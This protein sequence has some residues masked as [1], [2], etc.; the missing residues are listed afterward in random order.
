ME[1]MTSKEMLE[2]AAELLGLNQRELGIY[3]G[4]GTRTI[5]SWMTG[6]REC[7][8]YVAE[9]AYRLAQIDAKALED[10]DPTTGMLRW[11]VISESEHDGTLDVYGSKSEAM[12]EA[13]DEWERMH[14]S[15]KRD[16]TRHEVGLVHV[17]VTEPTKFY[18]RFSWF[19]DKSGYADGD[20]YEEAKQWK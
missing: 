2:K 4:V 18:G 7:P 10:D 12:R 6:E 13:K 9:M 8:A 16:R 17:Q 1:K 5:N 14:P 15:D 19:V 3:I 20:V 11:A